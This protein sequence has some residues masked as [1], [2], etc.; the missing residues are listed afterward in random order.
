MS[1]TKAF[2]LHIVPFRYLVTATKK[3][4]KHTKRIVPE[5]GLLSVNMIRMLLEI[6]DRQEREHSM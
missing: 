3:L 5:V 1:K 2:L 6:N 4:Y